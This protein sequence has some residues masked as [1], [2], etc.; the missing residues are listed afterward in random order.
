MRGK[1]TI[2]TVVLVFCSAFVFAQQAMVLDDAINDTVNFFQSRLRPGSVVAVT[3]IEAET[4]ELSTFI[5]EE[6]IVSFGNTGTVRV[7]ERSRLEVLQS[8]LNFNISGSVSDQTAQAIGQMI[9]AQFLISGAISQY[10]DMYR[11]R[12]QVIAV[13]T[14]E[15]VGTR[16]L[17]VR[18]DPTL[19]GLLGTVDPADE[20]KYQ[21]I[22]AGFNVGYSAQVQ[23]RDGDWEYFLDIPFAFSIYGL[24]Q[25]FDFFGIA[26]DFGG[27]LFEGPNFSVLPTLIIRPSKFEI[28]L[29]LGAGINF[30]SGSPVVLGGARGGYNVGPGIIYAEIRPIGY[31]GEDDS[32]ALHVNFSLGYQIGFIPRK[33]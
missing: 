19:T 11:M 6:L 20:W 12:I 26:L 16:T 9:G 29:F 5:M 33:K 24:A 27:D 17:N 2:F 31:F 25:P 7:V 32:I 28:N 3:N 30:Y 10:R 18:Y 22:Y 15:I 23:R 4:R 8:E 14:A 13:E 21:W 1:R